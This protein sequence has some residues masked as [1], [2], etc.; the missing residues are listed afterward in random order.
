M[1]IEFLGTGGYH[2]NERRHTAGVMLPEIGLLF[3]A[4]TS[5]FRVASR[6]QTAELDVYLTHAHLDHIAGLTF[7]LPLLLDGRLTHCR[8]HAAP[9]TLHAVRTHLFNES[10]FP[11]EPAFDYREL[12]ETQTVADG[13][14][15]THTA[16][17][18]PGGSIDYR[19]D[20]PERSMAYITDTIADG[21]CRDFLAGVDVLIHE[22][23]F[24]DARAKLAV[25]TGH[26][27]TT[28]VA[29]LARDSGAGRLYLVH[30]DPLNPSD[31]PV[32]LP[33]ARRIFPQTELAADQ[34][35]VEF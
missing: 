25:E 20:W 9:A 30:V 8:V 21:S 4:G 2:P 29:E 16:L 27:H 10:V 28:P 19:I 22:C 32:D 1:R 17:R 7:L 35:V 5:A 23:Y 24:P 3:D 14:I 26:S 12:Q 34:M 11:I 15:L 6:L 31:D 13:G 33:T 18:H